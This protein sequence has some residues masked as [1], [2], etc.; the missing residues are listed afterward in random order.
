M[1]TADSSN[2]QAISYLRRHNYP[3]IRPSIKG[4]GSIKEGIKFLQGFDIIVHPRCTRTRDELQH[5][6]YVIDKLTNQPTNELPSKKNHV[7]DALRYAVENAR[8]RKR[9]AMSGAMGS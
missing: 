4:P 5:Y 7:I 2:P 1:I 6:L 3:L 8:R 9:R